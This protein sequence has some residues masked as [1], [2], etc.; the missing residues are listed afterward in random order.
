[1]DDLD[2]APDFVT[3]VTNGGIFGTSSSSQAEVDDHYLYS[4]AKGD[5][6]AVWTPTGLPAGTYKYLRELG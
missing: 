4:N 5:Y 3:E 1:M 6:K 2:E